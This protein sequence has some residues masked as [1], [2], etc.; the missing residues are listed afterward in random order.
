GYSL[1]YECDIASLM[2]APQLVDRGGIGDLDYSSLEKKLKGKKI[3][4]T[5]NITGFTEGFDGVSTPKDLETFFQYL[6]AFF[7]NPRKDTTTYGL[8]MNETR[9]QMKMINANPMYKFF[10]DFLGAVADNDPYQMNMLNY[11]EDVLSQVDYERAFYLYQERFANPADFTFVF[12]GNFDEKILAEYL[13]TYVASLPTTGKKEDFKNVFKPFP[14]ESQI[15]NIYAGSDEK[16]W[17]GLAFSENIDWNPQNEMMIDVISQALDIELIETIREKM[18]GVYSPM[19]QMEAVKYP[20]S[21][22]MTIVMFSCAPNNTDK[23]S[24]AVF[25]ILN[26]FAKKGPKKETLAKVK[27]QMTRA[28]ESD[29]LTNKFWGSYIESQLLQGDDLNEV[30]T[31]ADHLSGVSTK[32]V[33]QFMQKYFKTNHYIRVDLYP[34]TTE[35]PIKSTGR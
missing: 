29:M 27:E 23:L 16:S 1:Y 5:P 9:E 3:D 12:T 32:S 22:F 14:K 18:G 13:E 24:N 20:E 10:G 21:S 15:K 35:T 17:V 11:T 2:F 7:T 25:K 19:M 4:L 28:H 30:N 8:V 33:A 31:F 26:N 6:N 34:E